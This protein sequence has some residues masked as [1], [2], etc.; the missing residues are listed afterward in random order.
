MNGDKSEF[1]YSN[2]YE[3]EKEEIDPLL[4]RI[5]TYLEKSINNLDEMRIEINN[6]KDGIK[7]ELRDEMNMKINKLNLKI[8]NVRD[9]FYE[10]VNKI[11]SKI[12]NIEK[13]ILAL[14]EK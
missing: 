1:L 9:E 5:A 14:L 8:N 12:E 3:E 6:M 10:M 13:L 4:I 7:D 11:D 2:D